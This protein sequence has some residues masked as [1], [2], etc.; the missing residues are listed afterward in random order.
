MF[1]HAVSRGGFALKVL[2]V[3]V[4]LLSGLGWGYTRARAGV[5]EVRW[6][7]QNGSGSAV[8]RSAAT[9]GSGRRTLAEK[10]DAAE[11]QGR[12]AGGLTDPML[13]MFF[14]GLM[15]LMSWICVAWASW[16][17]RHIAPTW[18]SAKGEILAEAG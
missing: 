5:R 9:E 13:L 2:V 14:G 15:F 1:G 8:G 4:L 18:E 7:R 11:R 6:H 10:S 3:L 17:E 12:A 16:R